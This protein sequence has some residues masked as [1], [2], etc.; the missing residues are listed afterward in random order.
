M[1]WVEK[2]RPQQLVDVVHQREIIHLL[3]SFMSSMEMPHL[4]FY[5]PPGTGKTSTILSCANEIYGKHSASMVM[6]LNASDERGV[7]V[8]QKQIIQF[9]STNVMFRKQSDLHKLVILDEADSMS[10]AAQQALCDIMV[11]YDTLFCFIGNYQY[12][13]ISP[14]QSRVI[15]LLFTPIPEQHAIELGRNILKKEGVVCDD[16]SIRAIFCVS[17]G[18][19]RQ[20]VNTL[21]MVSLR[22]QHSMSDTGKL[23]NVIS[24]ILQTDTTMNIDHF[25]QHVL[26][27][28]SVRDCY[29]FLHKCI[30][31]T[32]QTTLAQWLT[33]IFEYV[34]NDIQT[35]P[36]KYHPYQT[37]M[38]TFFRECARIENT[39]SI[40]LQSDIQL[41]AL[42]ACVHSF[43]RIVK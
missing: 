22:T 35:Y 40:S 19:M 25:V 8:I 29:L 13:F 38:N 18:D 26:K 7:D 2:Y 32:H 41:F 36:K 21:Q 10:A 15:K 31:Q 6:H 14:L 20:F 34:L 30:T 1:P 9:S 23:T 12:A 16:G 27:C 5:G 17:K 42:V 24:S 37:E 28:S 3:R 33:D 43:V 11:Q 39:L 4:F